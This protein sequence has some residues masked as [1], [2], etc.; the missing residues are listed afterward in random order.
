MGSCSDKDR[1]GDSH[2]AGSAAPKTISSSTSSHKTESHTYSENHSFN[3]R[4][5]QN[6]I[7]NSACL[8]VSTDIDFH[9]HDMP[10]I[11]DWESFITHTKS[12]AFEMWKDIPGLRNKVFWLDREEK[13]TGG[14]Y[15][16]FTRRHLD[17]YMKT[18][19]FASM[20][21]VP[22]LKNV[23]HEVHENLAGGE[24]CADLGHWNHSLGK[25]AVV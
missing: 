15:T 17:E 2:H 5:T 23:H 21:K 10:H 20:H 7:K 18:D 14:F 4:P 8:F 11:K 9:S 19:L 13:T 16:F 6:D 1:G 12:G 24:L 25:G 3:V 22:F